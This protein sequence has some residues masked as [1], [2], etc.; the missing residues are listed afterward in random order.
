MQ[1]FLFLDY[2]FFMNTIITTV[3][4]PT[5][6]S[7]DAKAFDSESKMTRSTT[8]PKQ[9]IN[10]MVLQKNRNKWCLISYQSIH[11][12]PEYKGNK[13]KCRFCKSCISKGITSI[14]RNWV[15]L[16]SLLHALLDIAKISTFSEVVTNVPFVVSCHIFGWCFV[17]LTDHMQAIH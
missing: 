3:G 1:C 9:A 6:C 16:E 11:E 8:T 5:C 17:L 15:S 7:A 13:R 10:L 14:F 12:I 4:W 2:E